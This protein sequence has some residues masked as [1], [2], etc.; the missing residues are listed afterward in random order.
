MGRPRVSPAFSAALLC[1]AGALA[2]CTDRRGPV[3]VE[4]PPGG[5]G[6]AAVVECTGSVARRTVVCRP[7]AGG[8]G[9]VRANEIVYGGQDVFVRV[10]AGPGT[11]T[12]DTFAFDVTVQN[13]I[14][15]P[16]GTADGATADSGGVKV[17]FAAGPAVVSGTGD[18]TVANAD[19]IGS[20]TAVDQPFFRYV[21][22]VRPDSLS[23]T[24]RWKLR[25]TPGADEFSFHLS[26]SAPVPHPRG[27]VELSPDTTSFP[28]GGED[29]LKATVR[30][31]LGVVL[32][33]AP[34][35]WISSAPDSV[36]VT[37]LPGDT[38]AVVRG[39]GRGAANITATSGGGEGAALA[40][41]IPAYRPSRVT[42][43]GRQ[44]I[45]RRRLA[46]GTLGTAEPYVIRGVTWS[47]AGPDTRTSVSDP[48]NAAVRRPEFGRWFRT[49]VPLLAAMNANTV[50]LFIDPGFEGTQGAVGL[51]VLDSLY[52]RGIMVVM[53][54]D[55]AVGDLERVR[56]AVRHYRG[57]PAVLM[58]MVGNEWNISRYYQGLSIEEAAQRTEAAAALIHSLD[59]EHPVSTSY[60]DIH[61][62]ADGMRLDD[63]RRYVNEVCPSVDVWGLNIY[64]GRS[65]G[66]LFRQWDSISAKPMFLSE[67]GTDAFR[68]ATLTHPPEGAVDEAMQAD[69]DLNL[70]KDLFRNL[71]ARDPANVAL[72]GTV[73]EWNDEWW[74]VQPA[75]S[76]DRGGAVLDGHPDRFANEEYFGIVG[77][78][79]TPRAVY[80]ALGDAFAPGAVP[81]APTVV[82]EAV[83]SFVAELRKDGL[84]FFRRTGGGGGG[85]G[86][87]VA[88][89]DPQTGVV[90]QTL[91][92][93][94][95]GTR[96]S[97]TAM[98]AMVAHLQALPSGAV[99]LIATADEAGINYDVSCTRFP[100]AWVE[101]GLD[102][103]ESWGAT[104]IR[105]YCY[106]G[107][108]AM[109]A[110][111]GEVTARA[112]ALGA[113]NTQVSIRAEVALR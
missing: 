74:K 2:A 111:K 11:V 88:T 97:G 55:D 90:L 18:V 78:D 17:F 60:G 79:R 80:S 89:I 70:W 48:D 34:L 104:R 27:W 107:S 14:P 91:N 82:L 67:F 86:F 19:G 45:V 23:A 113:P 61:I 65:F 76:H 6:A 1:V 43:Q 33:G 39:I 71:S 42:V 93:D 54:V 101:A 41:S 9:G 98:N 87:N 37:P 38:L 64:R 7:S 69:W 99:V 3:L 95:W 26:V 30:N 24:R 103:L 105:D 72:G 29:T 68:S 100:Y 10:L 49:D 20:F 109:V 36:T 84:I 15:Q 110:V 35:S 83:S 12:A 108:W 112:E 53:T 96:S 31:A 51:M 73:F 50:R 13:L 21:G 92:F 59:D 44:L 57:H 63:T 40:I 106:W 75:E 25:F 81:G 66:T 52:A 58:W 32:S 8:G 102:E 28:V 22:I 46:N 62:D 94:T 5:P 56:R 77:I 47:P 4:P 85:R 16:I